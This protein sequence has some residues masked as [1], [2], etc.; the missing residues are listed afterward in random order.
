MAQLR[1]ISSTF[2]VRTCFNRL[3]VVVNVDTLREY[4]PGTAGYFYGNSVPVQ[5]SMPAHDYLPIDPQAVKWS[6]DRSLPPHR[7]KLAA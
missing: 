7:Q 2:R 1:A 3:Y 6:S 5:Y 4:A